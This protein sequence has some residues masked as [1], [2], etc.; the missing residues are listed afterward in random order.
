MEYF[1]PSV[2]GGLP[3]LAIAAARGWTAWR[4]QRWARIFLSVTLTLMPI[5][6]VIHYGLPYLDLSGGKTPLQEASEVAAFITQN[7]T[8]A[9]Q[10][11]ALGALWT[12]IDSN[13]T[14][15]P[16]MAMASFSLQ[17]LDR[18]TAAAFHLVNCEMIVDRI[19]H[20]EFRMVVISQSDRALFITA[21]CDAAIDQSLATRYNL[22]LV[23][24]YLSPSSIPM[25]VYVR[26]E[27]Q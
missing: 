9:D 20:R 1:V 18:Q 19:A 3:L 26:R 14:V 24:E 15:P 16:D 12:V 8:S 13:R 2:I 5:F 27:G 21:G 11:M 4:T 22:G 17:P 23:K 25:S 6:A 7:S 10:V